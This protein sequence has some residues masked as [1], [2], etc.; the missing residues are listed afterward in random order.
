[1]RWLDGI[2]YSMDM[3]V[4]TL[5]E[6]A[7]DREGWRAAVHGVAESDR[8]ERLNTT[9]T[10]LL[11]VIR[12]RMRKNSGDLPYTQAERRVPRF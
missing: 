8:T 6:I 4:N 1:M 7:K 11:W 12:I 9:T 10:T 3:S 2:T 5:Q